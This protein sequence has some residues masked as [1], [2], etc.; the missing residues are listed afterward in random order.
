MYIKVSLYC[1]CLSIITTDL[2][3]LT[4]AIPHLAVTY[5]YPGRIL[6]W[7]L[8]TLF[9]FLFIDGVRLLLGMSPCE[10]VYTIMSI[11]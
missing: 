11:R 6:G 10:D 5:Y 8:T 1:V 9:L 2:L 7:E 4:V 3:S